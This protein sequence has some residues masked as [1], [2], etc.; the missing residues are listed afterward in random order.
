LE[1]GKDAPR[2]LGRIVEGIDN[3]SRIPLWMAERLRRAGLRSISPVVDVTNYV[4]LELGQ[5]LHAF[6]N[7]ALEGDIVVRHAHAGES[8][9][10]LDGNEAKLDTGFVLIADERQA[11]AVAGI[12][13]GYDSRVTETTRHIFLESAHFAP[14]AIMGRAR[15]LGLHT[16]ASHRFERGVDPALPRRALERATEL[17]LL[18]A[19]GKAGP[20]V[21]AENLADMSVPTAVALRRDRLK[22]VLGVAV[23]DAAGTDLVELLRQS[24]TENTQ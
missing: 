7:D 11:L 13:G 14:A 24:P 17:L 9:K 19:G 20:I 22:R 1:A 18:I 10:L 5:P 15:K 21:V 6:D 12:M 8:L 2:Y 4:M 16:D 3:T 23:A